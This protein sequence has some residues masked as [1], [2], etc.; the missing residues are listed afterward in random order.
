MTSKEITSILPSQARERIKV[1]C[2]PQEE[3]PE[4]QRYKDFK[5]Y[6]ENI[7]KATKAY[8]V[9]Q[10]QGWEDRATAEKR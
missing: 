2:H 7:N 3:D 8:V 1:I 5:M 4:H 10:D 9:Q 6:K